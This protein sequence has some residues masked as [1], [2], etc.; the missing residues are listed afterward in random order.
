[1]DPPPVVD[2]PPVALAA[3]PALLLTMATSP[4]PPAASVTLVA[5]PLTLR[6]CTTARPPRSSTSSTSR[7]SVLDALL[8]ADR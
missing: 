8:R 6:L 4:E 3:G 2:H 1:L 7:S 5:G